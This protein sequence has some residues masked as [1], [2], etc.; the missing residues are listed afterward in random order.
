MSPTDTGA[1][2]FHPASAWTSGELAALFNRGY[3]GYFVPLHLDVA[4]FEAMVAAQDVRLAESRVGVRDGEPIAFAMLAVRERRGW[5]GGM[6]VVPEARGGGRRYGEAAMRAVLEAARTLGLERVQLEVMEANVPARR[7]YE[8]LGF[9]P[10]RRLGV[11]DRAAGTAPPARSADGPDVQPCDPARALEWRDRLGAPPPPWQRDR[12]AI[13]RWLPDLQAL[14]I[15]RD[16]APAAIAIVRATATTLSVLELCAAAP[17]RDAALDR[18]LG[19]AL[20][21]HPELAVRMLNVPEDD[22]ATLALERTGAR[23]LL[24]QTEMALTLA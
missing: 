23:P 22:P 6:G 15:E 14:A 8:R 20:R 16:G 11:W 10:T 21:K 9:L 2:E 18:L 13:E 5:I 17:D 19:H 1:L 12:P 4:A 3:E 24:H 7:I